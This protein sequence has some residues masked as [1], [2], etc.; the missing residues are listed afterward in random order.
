MSSAVRWIIAWTVLL[1]IPVLVSAVQL[2]LRTTIE[3]ID[4]GRLARDV[5]AHTAGI[6]ADRVVRPSQCGLP[7][8]V[9]MAWITDRQVSVALV[10]AAERHRL[11]QFV[12]VDTNGSTTIRRREPWAWF[13]RSS[14]LVPAQGAAATVGA[15]QRFMAREFGEDRP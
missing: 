10:E 3:T 8:C 15:I 14:N 7:P 4:A 2:W 9:V 1:A 12:V 11:T 13:W 5:A 6:A